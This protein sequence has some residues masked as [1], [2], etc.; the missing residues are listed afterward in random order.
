VR[1]ALGRVSVMS[2]AVSGW[3][4]EV[5]AEIGCE[6]TEAVIAVLSQT[7]RAMTPSATVLLNAVNAV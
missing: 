2:S 7:L 1:G 3:E 4:T 6:G 5:A